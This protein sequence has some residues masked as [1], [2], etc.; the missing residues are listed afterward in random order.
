[1]TCTADKYHTR[2]SIS[3]GDVCYLVRGSIQKSNNPSS[4]RLEELLFLGSEITRSAD[5]WPR[6][7]LN[8]EITMISG[9]IVEG[10]YFCH[11]RSRLKREIIDENIRHNSRSKSNFAIIFPLSFIKK[12]VNLTIINIQLSYFFA[13]IT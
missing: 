9:H 3:S 2:Y 10:L 7:F 12:L 1:M 4:E 5:F 11:R 13:A 6:L 8:P